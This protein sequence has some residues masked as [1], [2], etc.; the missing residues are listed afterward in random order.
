[1]L[2]RRQLTK[3]ATR[4]AIVPIVGGLMLFAPTPSPAEADV[5]P[6]LPH[7]VTGQSGGNSYTNDCGYVSDVAS[8]SFSLTE[9]TSSLSA[10]VSSNAIGADMTLTI[11]GPDGRMCLD[12]TGASLMPSYDGSWPAGDYQVWV[13]DWGDSQPFTLTFD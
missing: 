13:G 3:T 5:L 2:T 1:M 7:T 10:T 4:L 8:Y 11:K 12:D 9:A 6:P